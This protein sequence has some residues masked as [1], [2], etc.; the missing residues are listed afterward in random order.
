MS[1]LSGS[2][3]SWIR[4]QLDA[5]TGGSLPLP[6]P[7]GPPGV[8][9][10][11]RT[12]VPAVGTWHCP[13]PPRPVPVDT[14]TDTGGRSGVRLSPKVRLYM[15]DTRPRR[16]QSARTRPDRRRPPPRPPPVGPVTHPSPTSGSQPAPPGSRR[17][18]PHRLCPRGSGVR[19]SPTRSDG[20]HR[21]RYN[22]PGPAW[23]PQYHQWAL[24][25]G[26]GAVGR[27]LGGGGRRGGGG[28]CPGMGG[29]G[30]GGELG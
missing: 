21:S 13:P 23:L 5:G 18:A 20:N 2:G 1:G 22:H 27:A 14:S 10:T 12:P 17:R 30:A 4:E 28:G 6:P 8:P 11:G 15:G 3:N 19:Y 7:A 29:E 25:E 16:Q 26:H 9:A 24:A